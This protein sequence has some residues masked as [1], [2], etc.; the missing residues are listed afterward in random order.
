LSGTTGWSNTFAGV[1]AV[2]WNPLI[3]TGNG[4][5]GLSNNQFGFNITGASNIPIVV[6]ATANLA[7]PV[8]TTLQSLTLT[9]GSFYFSEPWQS[10]SSGRF[11]RIGAP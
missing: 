3:E 7:S 4:S 2:L 1:P 6:Q 11:Y 9:N 8:W 10:N 5:F